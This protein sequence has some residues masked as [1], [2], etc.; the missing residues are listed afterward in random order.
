MVGARDKPGVFP[1]PETSTPAHLACSAAS[2]RVVEDRHSRDRH[3]G[4]QASARARG[5]TRLSAAGSPW[6]ICIWSAGPTWRDTI[7]DPRILDLHLLLTLIRPKQ[8]PIPLLAEIIGPFQVPE[9]RELLLQGLHFWDGGGNHILMLDW[10]ER[11]FQANHFTHLTCPK[12]LGKKSFKNVTYINI[13]HM[14]GQFIS[15]LFRRLVFSW[16]YL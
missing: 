16:P 2:S 13:V 15:A 8:K 14:T 10:D 1:S 7:G 6:A 4:I 9:H 5:L 12:P 11:V 3:P